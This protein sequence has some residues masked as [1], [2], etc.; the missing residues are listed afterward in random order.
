MLRFISILILVTQAGYAMSQAKIE[1]KEKSF[2]FGTL[3][4]RQK[5]ATHDFLFSNAG[6]EPLII[7]DV[8]GRCGCTEADWTKHPIPPGDTGH[9]TV[10]YKTW[11]TGHFEKEMRI[12]SNSPKSSIQI[13]GTVKA[14]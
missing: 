9:I 5:Y 6:D 10:L 3:Y 4:T 13:K 1:L 12:Y 14:R 11:N 2:N 8:R 7:K